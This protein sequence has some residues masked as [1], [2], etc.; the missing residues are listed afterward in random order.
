MGGL[1]TARQVSNGC[2]GGGRER[3]LGGGARDRARRVRGRVPQVAAA[4]VRSAQAN[5][6]CDFLPGHAR[7]SSRIL[8]IY[9]LQSGEN[10]STILSYFLLVLF[11][12]VPF[13]VAFFLILFFCFVFFLLFRTLYSCISY[14]LF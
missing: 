13:F 1:G 7:A 8:F 3:G 5:Q 11:V 6:L 2:S 4:V 12:S 10:K 9:G 14:V